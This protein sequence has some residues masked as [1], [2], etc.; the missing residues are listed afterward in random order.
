MVDCGGT[1]QRM[2]G[3]KPEATILLIGPA[4]HSG[5]EMQAPDGLLSH[6][7]QLFA[8]CDLAKDN[9]L[10]ED[11]ALALVDGDETEAAAWVRQ[12]RR[13][14]P[15]MR[16]VVAAQAATMERV[17]SAF[18][19]LAD[20]FLIK[21]VCPLA[22][23]LA[24]HRAGR[25]EGASSPTEDA[26]ATASVDPA[27]MAEQLDT[28][29]LVTARQI[30]EKIALL[31]TRLV[32]DV[33]G[34]I[35]YFNEMPTFYA[36]HSRS[37]EV[38][39]ANPIYTE[40]LGRRIGSR[41]WEI[42]SGKRA[43]WDKCPVGKTIRSG[44]VMTLPAVVRYHSGARVP[45]VVH[46]APIY[47][48]D[49]EIELVLEVFAGTREIERL[50]AE[51]KTTQQRFEQLFD[52]VPNYIAVL[53]R[54]YRIT[55]AN[56]RFREEFGNHIGQRFFTALM[57]DDAARK[58]SPI[59]QT[60]KDGQPH[61]A[62]MTL[63][64]A[65][66]RQY[67]LLAWTAPIFTPAGKLIQIL[68]ILLD[69]TELRSLQD[70][71]STL[72]MM[73]GVVSHNLKGSLTG[74]DA[75]FYQI[76]S[77]FYRNQAAKIE[78]GLEVGKLITDRIRKLVRDI[79]YYAKDRE[80]ELETV[81]ARRFAVELLSGIS[82]RIRGSAVAL[83]TEMPMHGGEFEIDAPRLRSALVNIMENALDACM[84]DSSPREHEIRF[85]VRAERNYVLFEIADNG[86]G[87]GP[88]QLQRMF[89]PFYSTKGKRGT[90]LGMFIASQVV[91]KHGGQLQVESDPGRGTRF[92][93]YL[94][95]RIAGVAR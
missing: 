53:D 54:R 71:L 32:R 3:C 84:E 90:G 76:D 47:S 35:R 2:K 94:P 63:T 17:F 30:V 52:A 36:I 56:R 8:P 14:V 78:E 74:L 12:L 44:S 95:R 88:E 18:R 28:E 4:L 80:L 33:Q 38:L 1:Q 83:H 67:T 10:P 60:L 86:I 5:C 42:Y 77:G 48:N 69:I 23:E 49:G 62:E 85:S 79:L 7:L 39:A 59:R 11:V 58:D 68:M 75:A 91:Q 93:V 89:T 82:Q 26:A 50:G 43:S 15:G 22:V 73:M 64:T 72:G 27:T 24:L 40:I 87:M 92:A 46:T 13:L 55:A 65:G 34:G 16:L 29:R 41:S 19:T 31:M 9:S 61:Q 21:P 70:N 66:G 45:V 81:N 57:T 20:D 51:I 6:R 37:G 25:R